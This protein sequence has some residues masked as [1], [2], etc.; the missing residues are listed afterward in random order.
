MIL[1]R[2]KNDNNEDVTIVR[3]K[4]KVNNDVPP[5]GSNMQQPMGMKK[6]KVNEEVLRIRRL[7]LLHR[8]LILLF[9]TT[10]ATS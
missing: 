1:H 3:K 8:H 2:M 6:A 10:A 7:L 5:Q 9:P 4:A